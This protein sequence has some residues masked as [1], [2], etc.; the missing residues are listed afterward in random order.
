DQDLRDSM[1]SYRKVGVF[2]MK[3]LAK[4]LQSAR[5][6]QA[7]R[8]YSTSADVINAYKAQFEAYTRQYLPFSVRSKGWSKAIQYWRSL[9]ELPE[10]CILAYLAIKVL[11]ALGNSMAEERTVSRF[12]RTDTRDRAN[13]D[14]RTI[15]A[16]TKIYQHNQRE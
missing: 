7:F 5:N 15:V 14:A 9:E 12:T 4:D 11:S 1:P 2:L 6:T 10:A 13:Q 8:R 3:V 16:Q